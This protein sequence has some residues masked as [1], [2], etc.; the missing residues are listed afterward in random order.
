MNKIHRIIW[1]A[2]RGAFIVAHELANSHGKP[3]ATRRNRLKGGNADGLA[4]TFTLHGLAVSICFAALGACLPT[5]SFAAPPINALPTN[6]LPT[7]GQIVGGAAAGNIASHSNAMTVT[8]N[9]QRMIANWDSFNIGSAAS[10][11]FAQPSGGV[12]LNRVNGSAPSEIFG[13]LSSSGS[14]YLTNPN[15]VLFGRNAQVDVGALVATTMKLS[16]KDFMAGN[17]AFTEGNGAV[18]N[19]GKLTAEQGGYIALLAPEVR[20]EGVISASLGSVVLGGAE[21]VTLSHDSS[22]LLYAVDKGAVQALVENKGL[23]EADGG[24]VI[25]SARAANTLASAVINNSGTIEAK[26]LVARGGKIMLEGDS[27]TLASGSILDAS[28]ETGGGEVRV[29][30]DFVALGGTLNADGASG[31]HITV[32]SQ[33]TLSLAEQVHAKGL[34]GDGGSISYTAGGRIIENDG[35]HSDVSGTQ[36]GG[37]ITV[38]GGRIFSS[39]HYT[40]TGATGQGGRI[41]MTAAQDINLLSAHLDASGQ[42]QGGLIRIG[43]TFQGGKTIDA[44]GYAIGT[45]E[46]ERFVNRWGSLPSLGNAEKTLINDS[47]TLNISASQGE[48]GA[49]IVWSDQQTTML[50]AINGTGTQ[51]GGAVEVSSAD[52]LRRTSLLNVNLGAG[53]QLLLD[54]KNITVGNVTVATSWAYA[55]IMGFGYNPVGKLEIGDKFG[56]AVALN[57]A[58]NRLAIGAPEDDGLSNAVANSGAVYLFSFSD[59]NFSGGALQATIGKGYSGGKN[60]NVSALEANDYFGTTVSLNG[61]GDRLAVGAYQDDGLNNAATNSGAAYLFKFT[62]GNFAGGTL[63][64][65]LGKGYTGGKN[66]DVSALDN[67]DFFG[68][69]VSLNAAGD[70]LAVGAYQDYGSGNSKALSGAVH[71]FTFADSDF[72]TGALAGSQ[73]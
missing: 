60:I 66:V 8:Q 33:G 52:E 20:N 44:G 47:S 73:R 50:G 22:G 30:G 28:G 11:H 49:A 63:Q 18:I 31:G 21:A 34:A 38:D 39:G 13:K 29:G 7:H 59:S 2:V 32:V 10:V 61:V 54:P 51:R 3:A 68:S 62:D 27:I 46:H 9:Q 41:D 71:L 25:L 1:S 65:T 6:A 57:A 70:R 12:A 14:V 24:Q 5:A 56:Q 37:S 36:N 17:Y 4:L 69:A 53:G 23:V 40:A 42:T 16:D 43:G 48:G 15:G 67:N 26:G 72:T 64:A 58:G 19:Q 35:S 45:P 55:A